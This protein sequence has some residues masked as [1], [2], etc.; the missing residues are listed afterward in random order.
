M[1]T[2]LIQ[3]QLTRAQQRMKQQADKN[4]SERQFAVGDMVFL[5]LQPYIQSSLA[6]RGNNKLLFRYYGPHRVLQR[7][8]HVAYKL[9]LPPQAKIHPVIH[10]SQLKKQVPQQADV[11]ED[12]EAIPSDP[13]EQLYPVA[14]LDRKFIRRAGSTVQRTQV[15]WSTLSPNLATWED[16][17][18]LKRRFPEASA[19]GQ[20]ASKGGGNVTSMGHGQ[21][22]ESSG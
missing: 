20:A 15:Q 9:D 21:K 16:E 3:Q 1:L 11:N 5:K 19:W 22:T 2:T 10:V 4:R 17:D 18:D 14:I 7:V 12:I 13:E 6:P 8:G